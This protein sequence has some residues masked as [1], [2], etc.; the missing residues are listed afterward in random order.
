MRPAKRVFRLL[1][2]KEKFLRHTLRVSQSG[3]SFETLVPPISAQPHS[4]RLSA[5]RGVFA[6]V[7]EPNTVRFNI[8][9]PHNFGKIIV[10]WL[11]TCGLRHTLRVSQY[12]ESFET[13][14]PPAL[15][16]P[17]LKNFRFCEG[18]SRGWENLT[19]LDEILLGREHFTTNLTN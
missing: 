14:V 7:G 13:L 12:C 17:T 1:S 19:W 8:T 9:R 15:L 10:N 6:R 11:L 18:S 2:L 3:E 16:S 5:Q 4:L